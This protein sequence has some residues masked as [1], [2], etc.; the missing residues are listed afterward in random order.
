MITRRAQ[1]PQRRISPMNKTV[2]LSRSRPLRAERPR[3]DAADRVELLRRWMHDGM[4]VL[5]RESTVLALGC[6]EA[7]LAPQLAEYSA[8]VT[9]LDSS[10]A[11]L[12]QL[13]RRFPEIAFLPHEPANPLPFA[14]DTFDALWC[15]EFLDRVFDPAAALADMHRV[16]APGGRLLLIVPDHSGVRGALSALFHRQER[17]ADTGPRVR[18]FSRRMLVKL[19]RASGFDDVLAES[20]DVRP[21]N[22]IGSCSRLLLLSARKDPAMPQLRPARRKQ[23][24]ETEID[25]AEQLAYAGRGPAVGV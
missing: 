7:F 20:A 8:D 2:R 21:G 19:A 5:P 10:A 12:A 17:S 11:Q 24:M 15:C 13:A 14:H 18:Q 23:T 1:P 4:Q 6:E 9:I 16:L 22:D 3:F 25:L